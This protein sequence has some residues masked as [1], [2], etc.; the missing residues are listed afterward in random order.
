MRIS[1]RKRIGVLVIAGSLGLA[2]CGA[3][4]T[5]DQAVASVGASPYLQVHLTANISGPGSEEASKVLG[6]LSIDLRY[7]STDGGSLSNATGQVDEQIV[8]DVGKQS[9]ADVRYLDGNLYAM[10]D[11]STLT[12][13]PGV[14]L[15][16]QDLATAQLLLGGRWFELPS[17]VIQQFASEAQSNQPSAAEKTQ[18]KTMLN[19]IVDDVSAVIESAPY[20]TLPDGG[21]QET[22]SLDSVVKAVLPTLDQISGKQLHPTSVDGSYTLGLTMSGATATGA[23]IE[24]TV[25]DNG[26]NDSVGLTATVAHDADAIATPSDVTVIT[27][28]LLH[29]LEQSASGS[30]SS[31]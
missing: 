14:N 26:A 21:F 30:S 15:S 29:E 13:L 18:V 23:S 22:G 4:A 19:N 8:V 20:T 10:V 6:D 1:P 12:Q 3:K 2:A 17:S 24:I 16:A 27:P 31:L 25:A 7:A 28:S 11:V 5:I 9:L